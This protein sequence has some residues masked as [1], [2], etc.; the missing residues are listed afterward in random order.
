MLRKAG[1][2]RPKGRISPP[3][4]REPVRTGRKPDPALLASSTPVDPPALAAV[5]GE[6]D[7][8][9]QNLHMLDEDAHDDVIIELE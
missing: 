4:D 2:A 5:V 9:W 7:G 3:R 8:H 6:D 1:R